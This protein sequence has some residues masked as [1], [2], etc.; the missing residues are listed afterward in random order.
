MV[1]PQQL[2]FRTRV[3]RPDEGVL[4]S[5]SARADR[6]PSQSSCSSTCAARS[7]SCSRCITI[8]RACLKPMSIPRVAT[9]PSYQSLASLS[10]DARG[11]VGGVGLDR[12][13]DDDPVPV[14]AGAGGARRGREPR[15]A[16]IVAVVVLTL[17]GELERIPPAR[18]VPVAHHQRSDSCGSSV[19]P[20]AS[21][22]RPTSS[23]ATAASSI[24]R[25][26]RR[27]RRCPSSS[28][29]GAPR[30]GAA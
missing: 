16:P 5:R 12:V 23:E 6:A 2:A 9:V 30:S 26:A 18:L 24:P 20:A 29:R 19:P 27:P 1:G 25:R 10:V 17:A 14:L 28:S 11:R 4:W 8:T 22:R 7:S 3:V 15:A 21:R 13:V